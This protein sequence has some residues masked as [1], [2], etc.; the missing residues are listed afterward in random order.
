MAHSSTIPAREIESNEDPALSGE[1]NV[2]P[3]AEMNPKSRDSLDR[4]P[5]T[6]S[7]GE[8][9]PSPQAVQVSSL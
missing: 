3:E 8:Q 6:A 7:A 1:T 5:G 2:N 9:S 4:T